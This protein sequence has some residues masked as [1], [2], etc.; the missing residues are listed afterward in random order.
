MY[1]RFIVLAVIALILSAS[2]AFAQCGCS[3]Q[4]AYA[5]VVSGYATS[6]YAPQTAYY[7][8]V[9]Y[10]SYYAPVAAPVSYTSYYAPAVAYAPAPYVSYYA[11][12]AP[13]AAYY[14]P[15]ATYSPVVSYRAYYGVPGW[16]MYGAP[17]VYVPGEPVRNALKAV[18]P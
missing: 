6:Y 5:P 10:A 4:P 9:S 11:P 15:Y 18:T 8:P 17:R 12:A 2:T 16:S 7:S 13:Y 14:S 3:S 1:Q